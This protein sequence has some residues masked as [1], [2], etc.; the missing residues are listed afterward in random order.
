MAEAVAEKAPASEDEPV[1]TAR[2]SARPEPPKVAPPKV[3][4][5]EEPP[6]RIHDGMA[7]A[8]AFSQAVDHP[9]SAPLSPAPSDEWYVGIE[10]TP[11]GPMGLPELRDRALQR[12]VTLDSLVWRDGFEEWKPLSSFPELVTLVEEALRGASEPFDPRTIPAPSPLEEAQARAAAGAVP[13]PSEVPSDLLDK[14]GVK[15]SKQTSHPAAWVAVFVALAF[16]VTVGAVFLSKTE[17]HEVVKYVQVESSAK[18][19]PGPVGGDPKTIEESTVSGGGTKRTS[20]VASKAEPGP[21]PVASKG[22]PTLG[23]LGSLGNLGPA[24]QGPDVS[25]PGNAPG[26]QLDGNSIQRVV[27]NFSSS[28]RRGC[29]DTA[30]SARAPDAP[31][32]ARVGVTITI[33]ASGSVEDVTTT[34]DPRGYPALAHC[35]ESKVRGWRFPRSSGTTTAQVPFVF[36]AQ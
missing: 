25:S 34:G 36:A 5:E 15:S 10:G 11:T 1:P 30:L 13:V 14:I 26:G 17:Q 12:K 18:P 19:A 24:P 35:I 9:S 21:T 7:L 2:V 27:A 33:G 23:G 22:L 16:G 20:G 29:W 31:S 8:A 4:A 32:S 28:V 6:T 3:D